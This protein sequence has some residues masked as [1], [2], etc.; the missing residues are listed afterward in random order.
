[1]LGK[2]IGTI[3]SRSSS[4]FL[5]RIAKNSL[6]QKEGGAVTSSISD[7]SRRLCTKTSATPLVHSTRVKPTFA[8]TSWKKVTHPTLLKEFELGLEKQLI[9]CCYYSTNLGKNKLPQKSVSQML[10][11][12]YAKQLQIN[13]NNRRNFIFGML[14]GLGS[15]LGLLW[16]T[17]QVLYPETPKRENREKIVVLG[18]GWAALSFAS[19][20]D[21]NLY[22]VIM[23]SPRPYFEYTPLLPEITLGQV[24]ASR[25]PILYLNLSLNNS[26]APQSQ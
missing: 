18:S 21:T 25:Y 10:K 3:I 9:H 11:E 1:M 24:D 6:K 5:L 20:I 23:V 15:L 26:I 14:F 19:A 22:D 12:E 2:C 4:S 7:I 17:D 13:S 8:R 16:V